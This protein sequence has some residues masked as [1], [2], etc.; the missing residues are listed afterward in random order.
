M[1]IYTQSNTTNTSFDIL[2]LSNCCI[3]KSFVS[4]IL[5][6]F[7]SRIS[8]F[9]FSLKKSCPTYWCWFI[10]YLVD[11]PSFPTIYSFITHSPSLHSIVTLLTL[12]PTYSPLSPTSTSTPGHLSIHILL[13]YL[14]F[15]FLP[16]FIVPTSPP[17]H[18]S[19]NL[20]HHPSTFHPFSFPLSHSNSTCRLLGR[21][22]PGVLGRVGMKIGYLRIPKILKGNK[23]T[24][25]F[26]KV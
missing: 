6:T 20:P 16:S 17:F 9:S 11:L 10:K 22:R 7:S 24:C 5:R 8:F 14:P 13:S 25:V 19:I 18:P 26:K 1:W 21:R 3:C 15:L 12:T 2:T 23:I 4:R